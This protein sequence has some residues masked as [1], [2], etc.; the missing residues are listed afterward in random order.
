MGKGTIISHLGDAKY[1]V[2]LNFNRQRAEQLIS[3]LQSK[4]S[5]LSDDVA[6]LEAE[7]STAGD[8]LE[9][10]QTE[11][12]QAIM[13][14]DISAIESTQKEY[15]EAYNAYRIVSQNLSS[16]KT[17]KTSAEKRISTLQSNLP[18]D[19]IIEAWC[20]DHS[21]DL[22][23]E[24]GTIEVPGELQLVFIRPGYYGEAAFYPA[25]DGQLTPIVST[26]P[27]A[28]FYN[29][30]ML[31]GWQKWMPQY[32]TGIVSAVNESFAT[33]D[34]GLKPFYSSQ[35]NL[36]V[37]PYET[38]KDVPVEYMDEGIAAFSVGDEVVVEFI[39]RSWS[40]GK[41]IGFMSSPVLPEVEPEGDPVTYL[42]GFD[43][44]SPGGTFKVYCDGTPPIKWSIPS[45]LTLLFGSSNSKTFQLPGPEGGVDGGS[46]TIHVEGTYGGSAS[47]TINPGCYWG[48]RELT[49]DPEAINH[50]VEYDMY[51][52]IFCRWYS[53][54]S[55]Y[56]HTGH[57]AGGYFYVCTH[58]WGA[59]AE[60]ELY[61][62]Q[63]PAGMPPDVTTTPF[64]DDW[65][66][67]GVGAVRKYRWIC[68]SS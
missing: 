22:S 17:E 65:T 12:T 46:A 50:G 36:S 11:F 6:S 1:H 35:H 59:W 40:Q 62:L 47:H 41:V 54:R 33:L 53:D 42:T 5:E 48:E 58:W 30:A 34:V 16:K 57:F 2:Q 31:P 60:H 51:A 44:V 55:G 49:Y 38:L 43:Y 24:V 4:I 26:T 25:R 20:V 39:N 56:C 45:D 21:A 19:I 29:L 64:P 68:S 3:R 61:E 18:E 67:W 8:A 27:A 66:Y 52:P 15:L 9:S 10:A 37:N 14:G 13:D 23:G 28:T 7:K 32:R 63:C